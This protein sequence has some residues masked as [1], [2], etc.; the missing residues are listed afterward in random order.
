ME[1]KT[2]ACVTKRAEPV[3]SY[4][5]VPYNAA[6]TFN[7]GVIKHNGKYIMMFRNDAGSVEKQELNGETNIGLAFSDD[8]IKWNT[9]EKPVFRLHD[10]EIN[11]VYDPRLTVIDDEVY[12]CFATDTKHGIRGGIGKVS[13]DYKSVEV[14]SLSVP[15]NRNMALFPE[16][17]NGK[18]VRVERPMPVYGRYYNVNGTFDVWM[19]DSPDL[20]YWGNSKLVLAC[21][22][23]PFC[24][25]KIGP[26]APP[27]KTDKG[28][29]TIF[30]SVI[31]DK[32]IGK[33]GWEDSWQKKYY[34]GIM[35]LDKDDPS[36]VIGMS[37][38]PLLVPELEFEVT[39]GFRNEA[40]FPCAMIL[41]D[42]DEVKIYYSAGDMYVCLATANVNDLIDLC[43]EER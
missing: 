38:E 19:S 18:F 32:S 11:R 39:G 37:K 12:I 5:D 21:E 8:G 30:H 13:E 33:N 29:L 35:L 2:A 10:D 42:N 40:L 20:V 15:D 1:L 7:A 6:L 16:K 9:Y 27:I 43:S 28:W 41:D 26:G 14:I 24:N 25:D 17:I 31:L 4:K 3:F 34:V 36:K 23:V 22:D